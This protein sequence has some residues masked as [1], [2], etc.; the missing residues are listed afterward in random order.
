MP[1]IL[2]VYQTRLLSD[3]H[4]LQ[5]NWAASEL[6]RSDPATSSTVELTCLCCPMQSTQHDLQTTMH[7]RF[8]TVLPILKYLINRLINCTALTTD[9]HDK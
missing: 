8:I 5:Q 4:A 2:A 1:S 6:Q 7:S 9:Q 3:D